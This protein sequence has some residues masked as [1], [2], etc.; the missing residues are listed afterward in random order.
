LVLDFGWIVRLGKGCLQSSQALSGEL[1][2]LFYYWACACVDL[3]EEFD[4]LFL[5][6]FSFLTTEL[7]ENPEHLDS[8]QLAWLD[9][10]P[11]L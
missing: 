11:K 6:V 4:D 7:K 8:S 2:L 3:D 10:D 5:E 9:M 1:C